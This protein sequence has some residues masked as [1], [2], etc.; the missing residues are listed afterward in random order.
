[1]SYIE[2]EYYVDYEYNL[3]QNDGVFETPINPEKMSSPTSNI[4]KPVRRNATTPLR[5]Y[6]RHRSPTFNQPP[7]IDYVVPQIYDFD[8]LL[9]IRD[10]RL[11]IEKD[12][13]DKLFEYI[14][15][16]N[17]LV[18]KLRDII[19]RAFQY[20]EG[21][22]VNFK[23]ELQL[24]TDP[25]DPDWKVIHLIIYVDTDYEETLRLWRNIYESINMDSEI[26]RHLA[27]AFHPGRDG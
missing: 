17:I 21:K 7:Y 16:N 4:I 11:S 20:I 8:N 27:I 12:Q 18:E 19:K 23:A 6:S 15:K 1:M 5:I 3:T 24:F 9:Q 25:E 13:K 14:I 26:S 10:K 2:Y 22:E